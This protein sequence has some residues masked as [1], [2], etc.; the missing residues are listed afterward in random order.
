M[1]KDNWL[2]GIGHGQF[3]AK[4]NE[5][6]AAYFSSHSIDSKEAV[7]ADNSI[8]A[9]NDFGY[10]IT[11]LKYKYYWFGDSYLWMANNWMFIK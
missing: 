11:R 8:Y 3:K 10:V 5:Y 2:W 7:L 9:F 6:Q 4:Y 1:L